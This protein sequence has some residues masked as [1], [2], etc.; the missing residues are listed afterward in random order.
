MRL[1]RGKFERTKK[2]CGMIS[3]SAHDPTA[4]LVLQTSS[5]C[6]SVTQ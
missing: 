4:F 1:E 3:L 2:S 6:V 5:T